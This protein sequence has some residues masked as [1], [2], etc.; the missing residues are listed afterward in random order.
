M[1]QRDVKAPAQRAHPRPE[2]LPRA[3]A[4]QRIVS[5]PRLDLAVY[6][7]FA[8]LD[9]N[10]RVHESKVFQECEDARTKFHTYAIRQ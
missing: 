5:D 1:I 4:L 6:P 8:S 2:A 3:Q 7:L 10:A 9:V